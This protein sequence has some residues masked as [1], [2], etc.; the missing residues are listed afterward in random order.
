MTHEVPGCQGTDRRQV[1]ESEP[2]SPIHGGAEAET[3]LCGSG[4]QRCSSVGAAISA[5]G[6]AVRGSVAR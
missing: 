2:G 6:A 4:P 3:W 5:N 1:S